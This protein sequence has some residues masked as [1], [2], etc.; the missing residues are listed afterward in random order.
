M[1]DADIA[2]RLAGLQRY[3]PNLHTALHDDAMTYAAGMTV[4]RISGTFVAL[5]DVY[6]AFGLT[7]PKWTT[8][9][10]TDLA[11][12]PMYATPLADPDE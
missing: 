8:P 9:T 4:D 7:P 12:V 10:P 2:E 3:A 11:G 5:S 1:T 6:L